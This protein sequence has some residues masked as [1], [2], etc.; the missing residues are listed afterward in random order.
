MGLKTHFLRLED[1]RI[2]Q[3]GGTDDDD[4][5]RH[6][7]NV[8]FAG[9]SGAGGEKTFFRIIRHYTNL[10]GNAQDFNSWAKVCKKTTALPGRKAAVW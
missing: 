8:P 4:F 6:A 3:F 1:Q 10:S 5:S 2:L 9:I 7:L